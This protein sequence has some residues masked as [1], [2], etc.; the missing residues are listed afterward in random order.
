MKENILQLDE[1]IVDSLLNSL[2]N[3]VW[4][5]NLKNDKDI[6]ID[7]RKNNELNVYYNGGS[8]LRIDKNLH[9]IEINYK[10][11]PVKSKEDY[12]SL[13]IQDDKIEIPKDCI[14]ITL[15]NLDKNTIKL[16]KE[17]IKLHYC[18]D[19]EKG[20]QARY[21][22]CK[23]EEQGVFIDTEF[24]YKNDNLRIDL[25]YYHF[26]NNKIYFVEL[27]TKN[28]N[29]LRDKTINKEN[30][31]KEVVQKEEEE[32]IDTQ[33]KKY[34][35]FIKKHK[36]DLVE[37]YKKIIKLKY[38]H[39]L[40]KKD[41]DLKQIDFIDIEEKPILLIGDADRDFIKNYEKHIR[42]SKTLFYKTIKENT[43][44]RVYRGSGSNYIN[45]DK[46]QIQNIYS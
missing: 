35:E 20:I 33:L 32:K 36:S 39:N 31:L 2:E 37:Y 46:S 5:N 27:K 34:H 45:L 18:N 41:I 6:Y 13:I 29:R 10:F 16:I 42:E 1:C 26:N 14:N 24:E 8:I 25:V 23:D 3:Y 11:L 12:I 44:Y 17:K 4:W 19:S 22:L 40:L 38:K 28:D 30:E 9:N 7:I 21:A 15:N 43:S